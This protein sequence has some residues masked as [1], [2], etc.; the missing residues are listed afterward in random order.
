MPGD[1]GGRAIADCIA[2]IVNPSGK[3]P[4]TYPKATN[5]IVHYD[6]KASE[7]LATDFSNNAYQPEFDFGFGMSYTHF[8]YS[9][10]KVSSDTF[11]N[12]DSISI[13]IKVTNDGKLNGKEVVQLYYKDIVASITPSVKKLVAFEKV[14]LNV[15]QSLIVNLKVTKSDFSFINKDLKR[16]TEEGTIELM[17]S[18]FKHAIYVK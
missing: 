1:E 9:D 17:L 7:D 14:D 6:H 4:F 11:S 5:E 13:S 8:T 12:N 15:G 2:G 3:L 18:D 10:F 16:V